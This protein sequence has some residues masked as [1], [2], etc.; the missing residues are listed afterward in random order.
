MYIHIKGVRT[1]ATQ[2]R[3][4]NVYIYDDLMV[5]YKAYCTENNLSFSSI[6]N[7]VLQNYAVEKGIEIHDR[8]NRDNN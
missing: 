7:H 4:R 8:K 6:V 2:G 1:R 5:A 3:G